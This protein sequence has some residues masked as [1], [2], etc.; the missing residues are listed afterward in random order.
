MFISYLFATSAINSRTI[1]GRRCTNRKVKLVE[2]FCVDRCSIGACRTLPPALRIPLTR[3]PVIIELATIKPLYP[4][5]ATEIP[6]NIT[7]VLQEKRVFK[8]RKDFSD[9]ANIKSLAQY[10]KMYKES[11]SA[12]EKF[13][14]KHAQNELVWFKAWKKTLDWKEPFAKWFV[15]GQ[16]N[17]SYNCLDRYLGTATA[18]KAALI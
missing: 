14:A 13:W 12:P 2:G 1:W 9:K 10:Q 8:P 5:A 3:S 18:N 17:V 16:L 11:V 6:T 4:M 15:G 7:S